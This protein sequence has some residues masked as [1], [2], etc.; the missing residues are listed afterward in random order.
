MYKQ[1]MKEMNLDWEKETRSHECYLTEKPVTHV[2][3][4]EF[5]EKTGVPM[6]GRTFFEV[7]PHTTG[8]QVWGE[9]KHEANPQRAGRFQERFSDWQK[10]EQG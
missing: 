4:R 10:V 7:L 2:M 9:V 3:F 8:C 6:E 5:L 1:E